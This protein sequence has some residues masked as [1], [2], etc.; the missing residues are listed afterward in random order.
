MKL[1]VAL[2]VTQ[3]SQYW[4]FSLFSSHLAMFY[5]HA[6]CDFGCRWGMGS[7]KSSKVSWLVPL[8]SVDFAATSSRTYVVNRYLT[9]NWKQRRRKVRIYP[10]FIGSGFTLMWQ[11]PRAITGFVCPCVT[12]EHISPV[13]TCRT[14]NSL[15]L[16]T[17]KHLIV[18][19]PNPPPLWPLAA[20][21]SRMF[22]AEK[23][24]MPVCVCVHEV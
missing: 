22:W 23:Q 1:D 12:S 7:I 21:Y 14:E 10:V 24:Q 4:M 19:L 15:S 17:P 13:R 18:L 8:T 5:I 16:I 9:S 6:L 11:P 2:D 20:L 3:T